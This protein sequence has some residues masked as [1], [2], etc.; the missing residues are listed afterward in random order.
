[1]RWFRLAMVVMVSLGWGGV[2]LAQDAGGGQPAGAGGAGMARPQ[3]Q[4]AEA[5]SPTD[6]APRQRMGLP[7]PKDLKLPTLYLVG[8]STVRNGRGDGGGGQW[9]WGE[10]LVDDFD[11]AKINVVNRA[12][13]GLSSRTYMNRPNGDPWASTLAMIKPGDVVLIQFGHNDG[14]VP[15]E[16]TRARSS[17]PGVG[18]ETLEIENPILKMHETVHT[19]GWY[20]R[21]IVEDTKAKGATPIV[22]SLIP[23]KIWKDGKVARNKDDFA[24]WAQQVAEQEHVGFLDLNEAIARRYDALGEA[25]VEPLFGDPHTH[26]SRAGAELNAEVVVSCLKALK[27]DPVAGDFSTKGMA[28]AAYKE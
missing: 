14:G 16:P 9:G 12:I 5:G 10:P 24:G 28:V 11:P 27:K 18:E 7:V 3:V 15:D 19:Y 13:G 26:T 21:K 23:R 8:D 17:L 22:C 6:P 25:A 2:V 4:P 20:I 1:M